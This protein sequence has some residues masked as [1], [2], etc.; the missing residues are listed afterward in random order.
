MVLLLNKDWM[1]VLENRALSILSGEDKHLIWLQAWTA[2]ANGSACWLQRW[3]AVTWGCGP[4]GTD[5]RFLGGRLQ[6]HMIG[7]R[8]KTSKEAGAEKP[9]SL[10]R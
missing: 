4:D 3:H 5:E 1:A 7:N 10:A 2:V 6:G 9:G 8:G